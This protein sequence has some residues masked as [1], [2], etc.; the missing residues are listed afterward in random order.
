VPRIS[1]PVDQ[2]GQ[3][4]RIEYA[5]DLRFDDAVDALA[6]LRVLDTN[7]PINFDVRD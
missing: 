2:F 1:S 3:I 6:R 7:A 5:V 4:A